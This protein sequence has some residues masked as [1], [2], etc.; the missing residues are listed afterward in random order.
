MPR[1]HIGVLPG[2]LHLESCMLPWFAER[3]ILRAFPHGFPIP[4]VAAG[5]ANLGLSFPAP[6]FTPVVA[7]GNAVDYEWVDFHGYCI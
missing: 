1:L 6:G 7:H 3:R 2:N 5:A 4:C